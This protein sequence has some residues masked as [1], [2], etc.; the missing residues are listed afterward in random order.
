MGP[1]LDGEIRLGIEADAE[2]DDC[3]EAGDIA[4]QFPVFPFAGLARW[5][6]GPVEEVTLGVLLVARTGPAARTS[7][8]TSSGSE[9]GN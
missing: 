7:C 8:G 4:G 5:W 3:E 9:G 6:W 2:D 1:S